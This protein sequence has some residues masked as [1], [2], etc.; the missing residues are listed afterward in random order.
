M[1]N[2]SHIYIYE[3]MSDKLDESIELLIKSSLNFEPSIGLLFI[4]LIQK[5]K[6][7]NIEQIEKEVKKHKNF[8]ENDINKIVNDIFSYFEYNN[9]DSD[10]YKNL[11]QSYQNIDYTYF[12]YY[13]AIPT[14]IFMNQ[15]QKYNEDNIDPK[16]NINDDFYD[17]FGINI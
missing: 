11:Y 17:G 7:I 14:N 16:F 13:E 1:Y 5:Y 4:S 6:T 15:K 3:E 12:I 10:L 9:I 2:L 8:T